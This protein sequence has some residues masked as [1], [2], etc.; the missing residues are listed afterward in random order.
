MIQ[1][2]ILANRDEWLNF[3]HNY[4]GGSDAAAVV[5]LN[6]WKNNVELWEEK[7]GIREPAE[8]SENALVQYGVG[9][10][11]LLRELFK[12]DYPQYR[13]WYE[14]NNSFI[15]DKY[16]YAAASLDGLLIDQETGAL[17]IWECKTATI[18]GPAQRHKWDDGIPNNYY[19]QVLFYMAVLDASFAILKAQLKYQGDSY[20]EPLLVT[21]HYRI[22]RNE[23]EINYLM[24]NCAAFWENVKNRRRPNLTINI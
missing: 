17:G 4:L 7:T 15:N 8:L 6:P 2:V 11:P 9:A 23:T 12:L 18:S 14:E 21:K 19:C 10:E 22:E 24:S 5:G 20:R 13:M 3:R 1:K 16:P